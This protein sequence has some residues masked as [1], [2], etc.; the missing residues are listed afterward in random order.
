MMKKLCALALAMLFVMSLFVGM[1]P[2]SAAAT[3]TNKFSKAQNGT[4]SSVGGVETHSSYAM[5]G[6]IAVNAGD[7]I[8]IGPVDL[9][10]MPSP[11]KPGLV[12]AYTS[13]SAA[14]GKVLEG[15]GI[16]EKFSERFAI[17]KGT[18]PADCTYIRV[19]SKGT[20]T[21]HG[22]F[23]VTVNQE[24]SVADF[25]SYWQSAKG[26]DTYSRLYGSP[27]KKQDWGVLYKKSVLFAGD[28]IT[29]GSQDN[30]IYANRSWGGRVAEKYSMKLTNVGVSGASVSTSRGSKRIIAQLSNA[31]SAKYDYVILH[32]GTNDAMDNAPIGQ[33]TPKGQTSGFNT[34]TFA[35]ALEELFATAK[36][37]W[38]DAKIGYI[39][40]YKTPNPKNS[41]H[42][43]ARNAAPYYVEARKVCEKWG[44]P[45]LDMFQDTAIDG[46]LESSKTTYT[47]LP[48]NLHP[49]AAGYDYLYKLVERFMID[50]LAG[51]EMPD[52][53]APAD[54][55]AT[56]A[57]Q[58]P[59]ETTE[60]PKK[61]C[62]GL[63]GAG[64]F[65]AVASTAVA[66]VVLTRRKK[67]D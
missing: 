51:G 24:F 15:I 6:L 37:R 50:V 7:V 29:F 21:Q 1:L 43:G 48:D 36:T 39:I 40:N 26:Y 17:F 18:V 2:V 61:G 11:K 34:A 45:Y 53:N 30:G 42:T 49:N 28:S 5:S 14:S 58:T 31:T 52:P 12:F 3:L 46:V 63:V 47:M 38:P 10:T 41:D 54:P 23:T 60:E 62:R 9:T 32:G 16:A 25:T 44:I 67:E 35:G 27:I 64:V 22:I 59:E 13:S 8:T 66:G 4:F 19:V 56:E 33:V 55:P 57:P 65:A 20:N